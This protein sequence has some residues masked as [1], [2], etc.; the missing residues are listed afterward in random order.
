ML[1][2]SV[3]SIIFENLPTLHSR[4]WLQYYLAHRKVH[5][6]DD[7]VMPFE[8]SECDLRVYAC[9]QLLHYL[10]EGLD[11]YASAMLAQDVLIR[12]LV[13]HLF[14]GVSSDLQRTARRID[15]SRVVVETIRPLSSEFG[16]ERKRHGER[17]CVAGKAVKLIVKMVVELAHVERTS[18]GWYA[19]KYIAVA[20]DSIHCKR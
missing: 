2:T 9:L 19:N 3:V 8:R 13:L 6:S 17:V 4:M 11:L 18:K 16:E 5:R 15:G 20:K 1:S 14:I 7:L 10:R 12:E